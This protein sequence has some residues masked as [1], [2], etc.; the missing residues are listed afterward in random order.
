MERAVEKVK[1]RLLRVTAALEGAGVRYAVIG[2]HAVAAW[3]ATV[4]ETA[5]R[6]TQDVD[7]LLD[8]GEFAAARAALEA[9]GFAYRHTAGVDLFLDGPAAR[10]RDA[11]HV[12]FAGER[13]QPDYPAP[14]PGLA[15]I[16]RF[17]DGIVVVALAALVRMKLTSFRLKDRVHLLD[18]IGAGLL[19]EKDASDLPP[20]LACRLRELLENPDA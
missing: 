2:G 13:V 15:E 3:V 7:M 18:L 8:R 5:V 11:V 1:D 19:S 12:I 6:N 14:A 17:S 9:A 4:D 10:P 16:E 20:A